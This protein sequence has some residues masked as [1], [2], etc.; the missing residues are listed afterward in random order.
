M[1]VR[2]QIVLKAIELLEADPEGLRFNELARRIQAAL[3]DIKPKN[4]A[5]NLV[6]LEN[7]TPE[8]RITLTSP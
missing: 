8:R 7:L 5:S 1:T 4:I 6:I 3:P 2:Q